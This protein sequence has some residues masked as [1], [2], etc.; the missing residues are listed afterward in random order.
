PQNEWH[1]LPGT[2]F[3]QQQLARKEE[4]LSFR[5]DVHISRD[6]EH[7][8][9]AQYSTF[10]FICRAKLFL[11]N[12]ENQDWEDAFLFLDIATKNAKSFFHVCRK[13][14]S[15]KLDIPWQAFPKDNLF[16]NECAKEI[17][18]YR[19]AISHHPKIGKAVGLSREFLPKV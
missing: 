19:N 2:S 15:S 12:D 16:Q 11:N 18:K 14:F 7:M 3:H 10:Y 17:H 8:A 4:W 13:K 5:D 9:M 1:S 6:L